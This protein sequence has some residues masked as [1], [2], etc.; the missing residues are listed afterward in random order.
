MRSSLLKIGAAALGAKP[1]PR[2]PWRAALAS[3]LSALLAA[4]P[5]WC[6]AVEKVKLHALFKDK[7]ILMIDGVRRVLAAGEES[8]EGVKLV[9]TDTREETATVEIGGKRVPLLLGAVGSTFG[10]GGKG[11]V[12]LYAESGGH[13]H[14]EGYI[15][16]RPVRFLVDTGAT[17]IAL[18]SREAER[19]GLDYRRNGR[20]GFANTAAGVVRTYDLTLQKVQVG[21]IVLHGVE[22]GVIE[23]TYPIEILLGM[24]FLGQLDMKR[25]SDRMELM[26]R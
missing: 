2:H 24:S 9:A 19:L 11:R 25:E 8:P 21:E 18:S 15:N 4:A 1:Q 10:A 23:G 5:A 26:Q 22:A 16:E 20:P 7:A 12:T 14:A 6:G 13:F 3:I 17:A